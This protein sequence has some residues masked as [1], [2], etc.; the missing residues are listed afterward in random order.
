MIKFAQPGSIDQY[1]DL[2]NER[3]GLDLLVNELVTTIVELN[4]SGWSSVERQYKRLDAAREKIK[5]INSKLL[6]YTVREKY[7]LDS[8]DEFE[9]WYRGQNE[10][11]Y[12]EYLKY[13]EW[14]HS[15][16]Q[17]EKTNND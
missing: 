11:A 7:F 16:H 2:I 10:D 13:R 8:R 17:E 14:L 3:E 4:N 9:M 5:Q 12:Q 1:I 6:D 15:Q